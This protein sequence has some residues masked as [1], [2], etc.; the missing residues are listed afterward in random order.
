M[1]EQD[2]PSEI[3]RKILVTAM[4]LHCGQ[5]FPDIAT[6]T[7]HDK[8]CPEHPVVRQLA[9]VMDAE[10]HEQARLIDE[11]D[12]AVQQLAVA[13][14]LVRSLVSDIQDGS[15]YDTDDLVELL[16]T[17]GIITEERY[18]PQF[19]DALLAPEVEISMGDPVYLIEELW[20]VEP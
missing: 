20:R 11:R 2:G 8:T 19:H 12:A 4:C 10:R 7:T 18:N 15:M 9:K 5:R 17:L 14:R 1:V 3:D 6:A 13:K 16:Y